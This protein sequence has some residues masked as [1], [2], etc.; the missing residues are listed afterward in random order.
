MPRNEAIVDARKYDYV[1]I[2]FLLNLSRDVYK[3]YSYF[4]GATIARSGIQGN[5]KASRSGM[6][7]VWLP[8]FVYLT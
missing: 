7:K 4:A 8:L 5:A 3:A 6:S 1:P 2:A